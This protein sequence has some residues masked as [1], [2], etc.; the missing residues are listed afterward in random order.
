MA[1]HRQCQG[2]NLVGEPCRS[3]FVGED[4]WCDAHRPGNGDL[5]HQRA[6]RGA[7]ARS[8][9]DRNAPQVLDDR[10]L[11]D[12]NAHADVKAWLGVLAEA[13]ALGR[14]SEGRATTIRQILDTWLKA[15]AEAVAAHEIEA[16]SE[17]SEALE[18]GKQ[19][20][21][22]SISGSCTGVTGS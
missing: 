16:L 20:A 9:K 10:E 18:A 3:P 5:M 13:T 4:G 2:T 15:E 19:A 1:G 17:R 6:R 12:L 21:L 7:Y 8:A 14:I 22:R 11:P